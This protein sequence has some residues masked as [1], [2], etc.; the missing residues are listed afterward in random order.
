MSSTD[1]A[2]VVAVPQADPAAPPYVVDLAEVLR[3]CA[4]TPEVAICT[5]DKAPELSTT[6]LRAHGRAVEILGRVEFEQNKATTIMNRIEA[7]IILDAPRTL[8]ERGLTSPKSPAGSEDMRKAL[9]NVD[10]RYIDAKNRRDMIRQFS[11]WLHA[12]ADELRRHNTT[13]QAIL[14]TRPIGTNPGTRASSGTQ[15]PSGYGQPK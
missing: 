5:V 1:L 13:V 10:Q 3:A 9:V 2:K 6:L 7:E 12:K 14:G 4:R 8:L 11:A 15:Y